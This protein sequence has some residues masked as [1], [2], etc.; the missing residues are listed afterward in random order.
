MAEEDWYG[1]FGKLNQR[2]FAL[3]TGVL[4]GVFLIGA[5]LF[6]YDMGQRWYTATIPAKTRWMGEIL[7]DHIIFGSVAL[8]V[9][10]YH[11]RKLRTEKK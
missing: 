9:A 4:V 11:F 5:G 3:G 10:Y 1:P 7:W 6:G 8:A 2:H